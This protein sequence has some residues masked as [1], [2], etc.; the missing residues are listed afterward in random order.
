MMGSTYLK[1][2]AIVVIANAQSVLV[3]RQHVK[4]AKMDTIYL[5]ILALNARIFVLH[6]KQ[7]LLSVQVVSMVQL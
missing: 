4:S 5:E 6:V 1:T 3:Q 7:V 2:L